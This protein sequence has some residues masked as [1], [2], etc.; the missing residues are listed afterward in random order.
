MLCVPDSNA[1]KSSYNTEGNGREFD[2]QLASKELVS[3]NAI[4]PKLLD[5]TLD[6]KE[7]TRNTTVNSIYS[8]RDPIN[9]VGTHMDSLYVDYD[10]NDE[11]EGYTINGTFMELSSDKTI[12]TSSETQFANAT[13]LAASPQGNRTHKAR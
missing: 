4:T 1:T 5:K 13:V 6:S 8:P 12:N 7:L 10:E 3:E 11:A 9:S 2:S